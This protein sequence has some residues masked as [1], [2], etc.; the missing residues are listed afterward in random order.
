MKPLNDNTIAE[1]LDG[2]YEDAAATFKSNIYDQV[3]SMDSRGDGI[4]LI[5]VYRLVE[6]TTLLYDHASETSKDDQVSDYSFEP[7]TL[8]VIK[9]A[10]TWYVMDDQVQADILKSVLTMAIRGINQWKQDEL[11]RIGHI[12]AT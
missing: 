11:A 3:A 1:I 4:G 7:Y 6:K 10:S 2:V 5:I 9:L 12:I 8:P